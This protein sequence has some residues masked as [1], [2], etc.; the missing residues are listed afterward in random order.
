MPEGGKKEEFGFRDAG[1]RDPSG[2]KNGTLVLHRKSEKNAGKNRMREKRILF[3][4]LK[5]KNLT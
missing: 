2:E 5:G 3:L 1:K 4:L